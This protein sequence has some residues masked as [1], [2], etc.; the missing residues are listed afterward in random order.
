VRKEAPDKTSKLVTASKPYTS[1]ICKPHAPPMGSVSLPGGLQGP[2]PR[3]TLQRD[4]DQRS[5][6]ARSPQSTK[7]PLKRPSHRPGSSCVQTWKVKHTFIS[8]MS[9]NDSSL[10]LRPF[11]QLS[12]DY[13]EDDEEY[14]TWSLI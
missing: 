2:L 13:H 10:I 9:C 8:T 6:W 7:R 3:A 4:P 5:I 14:K 11:V 12:D 1:N